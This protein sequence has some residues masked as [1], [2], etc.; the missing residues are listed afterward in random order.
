[1]LMTEGAI[2]VWVCL[3]KKKKHMLGTHLC[4]YVYTFVHMY[5]LET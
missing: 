1:M 5:M 3:Q 2:M 4:V